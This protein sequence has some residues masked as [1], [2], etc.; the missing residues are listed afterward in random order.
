MV[1]RRVGGLRKGSKRR[2]YVLKEGVVG[3]GGLRFKDGGSIQVYIRV[4]NFR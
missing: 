2:L 4:Y 1:C 3:I